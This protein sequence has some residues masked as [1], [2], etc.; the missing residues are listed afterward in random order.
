LERIE[1]CDD[2]A[3]RA[4]L[5]KRLNT[6]SFSYSFTTHLLE[7]GYEMR[8]AQELLAHKDRPR[9]CTLTC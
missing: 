5:T 6:H 3:H 4:G 8:A 9:W 1:P 2:A 7:D